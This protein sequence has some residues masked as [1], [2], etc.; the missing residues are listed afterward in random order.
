VTSLAIDP[1]APS[2]VYAG[3]EGGGLFK[4]TDGAQSWTPKNN[5]L[6]TNIV[7]SVTVDPQTPSNLY[8]GL[9]LGGVYRSIDGGDTWL[10]TVGMGNLTVWQIAID[11]ATPSTL[12]AATNLGVRKSVN[13]GATWGAT[14]SM[15][16]QEQGKP[17]STVSDVRAVL[18]DASDPSTVFAGVQEGGGVFK[19]NN[20]GTTWAHS[21]T[22]LLSSFGNWRFVNVLA[23]DP[24][25]PSTL[26]LSSQQSTYRSIDGGATWVVF[27]A[28]L[29]RG[30]AYG[31]VTDSTGGA[32]IATVYGDVHTLATRP[33]FADHV[34]CFKASGRGFTPHAVTVADEFGT[35]QTTAIK[36]YRFCTPTSV[37]GDPIADPT[38]HLLCYRIRGPFPKTLV[39][40][41][42]QRLDGFRAYQVNKLDT[43]CVPA[44][45]VGV[46]SQ[47]THDAYRCLRGPRWSSD[48]L[49]LVL[50]DGFGSQSVRETHLD[51]LCVPTGIDGGGRI[52]PVVD[53]RCD[54]LLGKSASPVP[55]EL[56]LQD[57]FGTITLE[58]KR[59]DS[60]CV[61]A[62]ESRN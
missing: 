21:S 25:N 36:P 18:V 14:G 60:H 2:T 31:L 4:T 49:D 29:S 3:T 53:L 13:A 42:S 17:P 57:R 45:V 55:G 26:Y 37:S 47:H 5:G 43:L 62:L 23:Q 15:T 34:R 19:S 39:P 9:E 7:Y 28:G 56:T 10:P 61:P 35:A 33:S 12:Y 38:T 11:P 44:E 40:F 32:F 30:E 52:D 24:T 16:V 20:G 22:G 8:V 50:S 59:P 41:L 51:R 46:P 48:T 27:N 6:G 54:K 1:S 58:L